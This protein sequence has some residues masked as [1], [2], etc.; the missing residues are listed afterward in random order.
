MLAIFFDMMEDT[1]EVFMD[2]FFVF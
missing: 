2:D 1:M